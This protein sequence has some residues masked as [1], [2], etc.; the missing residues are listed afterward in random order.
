MLSTILAY[1]I[2]GFMFLG[3]LGIGYHWGFERALSQAGWTKVE[4]SASH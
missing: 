4:R 2:A 1:V 3:G